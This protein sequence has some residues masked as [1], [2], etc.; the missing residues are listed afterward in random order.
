MNNIL[1]GVMMTQEDW[2]LSSWKELW[3]GRLSE[4]F[5]L[6]QTSL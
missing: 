6:V 3:G 2:Y 4:F 5:M 1:E